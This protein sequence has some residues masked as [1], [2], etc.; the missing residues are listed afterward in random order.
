MN[1]RYFRLFTNCAIV[2]GAKR[3]IIYDL[4]RYHVDFITNNM[5]EI[6][7]E[8][9]DLSIGE[10]KLMYGK[11]NEPVIDSYFDFLLNKEYI[12]LC[13]RHELALFPDV[14]LTWDIPSKV[15]NALIDVNSNSV[16]DFGTIF[17]QLEKLG[18]TALQIRYFFPETVERIE[19]MLNHLKGSS[20]ESLA[21]CTAYHDAW[22]SERLHHLADTSEHIGKLILHSAPPAKTIDF[23]HE[24][25]SILLVEKEID[26]NAHC[27]IISP[28]YFSVNLQTYIESQH[29]NTCLNSKISIDIDGQIKNCPSLKESYGNIKNTSLQ[30]ALNTKGFK[31]LWTVNK[32]Q[33][34]TC[35]DCEFRHICVDCRAFLEDPKNRNSKPL[36]CG[37][38]PYTNEWKEWS[39]NPLKQEAIQHYNLIEL[40]LNRDKSPI[41]EG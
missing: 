4:Q 3:S 29:H 19:A 1:E 2:K 39:T 7:T 27:G 15:E 8:Y 14:D 12:F 26:S 11:A 5:Y 17:E 6:L 41:P 30:E 20:I 22:T 31:D 16:H 28:E 34:E 37:Y 23:E 40:I 32:D 25:L 36:K 24:Y 18:C 9:K 35:K 10:I 38:D 13:E 33:I 21:L